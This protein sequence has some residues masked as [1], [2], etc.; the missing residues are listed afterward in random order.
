MRAEALTN[1][2]IQE[3]SWLPLARETLFSHVNVSLGFV[4]VKRKSLSHLPA[5]LR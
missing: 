1:V 2:N 4:L 3:L 5:L